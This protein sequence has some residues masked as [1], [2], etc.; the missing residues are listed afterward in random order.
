MVHE[1]LNAFAQE[2]ITVQVGDSETLT[3]DPDAQFAKA[4]L[5]GGALLSSGAGIALGEVQLL[6]SLLEGVGGHCLVI[7]NGFGWS[8]VALGLMLRGRGRVVAMDACLEGM[9]GSRGLDLV[10]RIAGRLALPLEAVEAL[11][12]RDLPQVVQGHLGGRL[13]LVLVDSLHTDEQQ[14]LDYEGIRPFLAP[15]A[16]VIF[17][18]VLNWRMEASF[19]E[20][21]QRDGRGAAVLHRTA[22]GLGLLYPPDAPYVPLL[23]AYRG[24]ALPA[25]PAG[26]V[27]AGRYAYLAALYTGFGDRAAREKYLALAFRETSRA[28][29]VWINLAMHFLDRR[30]WEDCLACLEEARRLRPDWSRPTHFE[31][32]VA[33]FRGAPPEEVWRLLALA[34]EQAE[35]TPE[36]KLDAGYAAFDLGRL[37]QAERF[38]REAMAERPDWSLPPHLCSLAARRR[39]APAMEVWLL[40]AGAIALTPVS[41]ELK[42]D[43][44]VAALEAGRLDQ[45]ATLAAEVAEQAPAWGAPRRLLGRIQA[46]ASGAE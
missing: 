6:E 1:L 45:A 38:G 5:P 9:E 11:S 36:L 14:I 18:D 39:G 34:L 4:F 17:H 13:D 23:E 25:R 21:A 35:P 42:Y 26:N 10:N 15:G 12:P 16:L 28:E 32:L 27:W 3:Q 22:S 46:R 24:K 33:K 37:D 41:P 40:L 2:G 44:A 8:A 19:N 29:T 20:I 30:S 7:G 31:A 43:A